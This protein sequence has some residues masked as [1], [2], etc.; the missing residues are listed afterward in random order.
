MVNLSDLLLHVRDLILHVALLRK[1]LVQVPSL[2]IVLVL[3]VHEECLDVFGLGIAAVL[4]ECEIVVRELPL[5]FADVLDECLVLALKR[6]VGGVVLVDLL[7]L[8]LHL[9]DLVHDLR[10]LTL[11]QI[12]VVVAI[13]DLPAWPCIAGLEADDRDT[14]VGDGSL[15][16]VH[17]RVL[18]H[19]REVRLPLSGCTHPHRCRHARLVGGTTHLHP[20]SGWNSGIHICYDFLFRIIIISNI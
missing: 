3:Y 11:Q 18:A 10:I 6:H 20:L 9:V 1:H 16:H 2:L 5:V 13:I 14:V 8:A 7:D 12:V 15:H 4:I 19:A 17:L